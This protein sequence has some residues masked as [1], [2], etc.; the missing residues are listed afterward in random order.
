MADIVFDSAVL[1]DAIAGQPYEAAIAYHG[2]ATALS[3]VTTS[4][5]LPPG[6]SLTHSAFGV[7]TGLRVTGTPSGAGIDKTYTF[8]VKPTDTA[9]QATS[10]SYSITVRAKQSADGPVQAQMAAMWPAQF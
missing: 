9:G 3:A 1:P 8:Q 5:S 4:G 6:L 2:A 10:P 7:A